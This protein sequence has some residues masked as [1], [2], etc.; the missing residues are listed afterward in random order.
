VL[1]LYGAARR[2]AAGTALGLTGLG[3]LARAAANSEVNRLTGPGAEEDG[4]LV[5]DQLAA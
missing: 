2:G 1:A 5:R 3:L 4:E